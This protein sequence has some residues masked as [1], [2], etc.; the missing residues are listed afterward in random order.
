MRN[1]KR[2]LILCRC[3]SSMKFEASMS[4]EAVAADNV[5]STDH[6]CTKNIELAEKALHSNDHVIIACQQQE[7][8][9]E[10]LQ[11]EIKNEKSFTPVLTT[12]DIR[13]RAGWTTDK[14]A[15]AKQAALL[16]EVNLESPLTQVKE[17]SSEG[18]CLILGKDET[19]LY[20]AAKLQDELAVT[21]LIDSE[22][23]ELTPGRAFNVCSGRLKSAKGSLGGFEITVSEYA[24]LNPHGRGLASFG[25]KKKE[26]SSEC[27]ILIDLRG[28]NS[29]FPSEKK[30]DGYLRKDP[31]DK[32][33]IEELILKAINLKGEFEKTVYI[34]FNDTKCA[35]SRAS[36]SGCSRCLD[37]CP[38]NAI[39]PNGDSVL[40]NPNICAGCGSCSS[41]CPSG[42]ASYDDPPFSFTLSRIQNL[43]AT[44]TKYDRKISPRL[45][46][47]DDEFGME[48]ITLCARY[49][50]GL[51]SDL[52]PLNLSHIEILSNSEILASLSLGF[53]EVIILKPDHGTSD[54]L[55]LQLAIC[56]E[57]LFQT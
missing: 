29:L 44:F 39:T 46:F 25:E 38:T 43:A 24:E 22:Y 13:D 5:L 6:L 12:V 50:K 7:V 16:S 53:S 32:I 52:I 28:S 51:P 27:D 30:R 8:L 49:G 21:V 34:N 9:F 48:L 56:K 1:Q 33:G 2:T 10:N 54:A 35:H 19:A 31:N 23:T 37:V 3:D 14:S 47:V 11:D 18:V 17:I 40:I 57:V 42:A 36:R 45:L 41:V 26:A 4:K 15:Y 20:V 55:E